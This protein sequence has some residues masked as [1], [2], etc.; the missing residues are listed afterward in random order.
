MRAVGNKGSLQRGMGRVG[1]GQRAKMS[2]A[3]I[4]KQA[5]LLGEVERGGLDHTQGAWSDGGTGE[6]SP[7]L[8]GR[9]REAERERNSASGQDREHVLGQ[10][11]QELPSPPRTLSFQENQTHYTELQKNRY[12]NHT[13]EYK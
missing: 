12:S 5:T 3:N 11:N 6:E 8:P 4:Q 9:F 7:P 2:P 13:E 1:E 10:R